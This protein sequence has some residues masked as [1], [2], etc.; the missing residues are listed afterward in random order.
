[1]P[2]QLDIFIAHQEGRPAVG[3]QNQQSFFKAGHKPGQILEI[4]AMLHVAIDYQCCVAFPGHLRKEL[5]HAL[6]D[7]SVGQ[8]NG[9]VCV[10]LR[11]G[12]RAQLNVNFW[13]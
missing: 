13:K 10:G 3:M 2:G 4:T 6:H 12:H 7:G 8:H 11:A 9:H 1:M 5:L